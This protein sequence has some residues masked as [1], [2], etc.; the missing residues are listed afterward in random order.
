MYNEKLAAKIMM[1]L[2]KL[3]PSASTF[4]GIKGE[5]SAQE[6]HDDQMLLVMDAL[7]KQGLITGGFIRTGIAHTLRS[8]STVQLTGLGR[9][10]IQQQGVNELP[11]LA[12]LAEHLFLRTARTAYEPLNL[13][14]RDLTAKFAA[15]G[16]ARSSDFCRS[17]TDLVSRQLTMLRDAFIESYIGTLQKTSQGITQY[18]ETWLTDELEKVWEE[19]VL[20]AR[21]VASILAQSTGF[22][23]LEVSG[24]AQQVEI[25]GRDMKKDIVNEIR[26]AALIPKTPQSSTHSSSELAVSSDAE[27]KRRVFVI[28]GRDERLRL[29]MFTFL[30]SLGLDP[31]EWPHLLALSG[32]GSPYV[33]EVL[34]AAFRRVQAVVV[35][36]TPDEQVQLRSDLRTM[37]EDSTSGMQPRPNVLFEAGMAFA[38]HPDRTVLVQAGKTRTISDIAGRHLVMMDN[39]LARRQELAEKLRLA[40]CAINTSGTDWHAAG[41][42]TPPLGNPVE[43]TETKTDKKAALRMKGRMNYYYRDGDEVPFCPK[44]LE[45]DKKEI[46]LPASEPW[47]GGIRRDCRVCNETYWEQPM[48]LG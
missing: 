15:H 9:D 16:M 44:C 32:K 39:S 31:Q 7:E 8:V 3:F 10:W 38:I 46:H 27:Q 45:N 47:N 14:V 30:R 28:Y 4:D 21:N 41:D 19:Q 17:V 36:L 33:G 26:I 5:F 6:M 20:R 24:Y 43:A 12:E 35:L 48:D 2:E 22:S 18:R 23:A 25:R 29:A 13:E 42:L 40:G 1:F 11:K 34:E 37:H